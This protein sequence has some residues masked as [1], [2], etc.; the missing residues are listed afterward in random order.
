MA[1]DRRVYPSVFVDSDVT[2]IP[3]IGPERRKPLLHLLAVLDRRPA[4]VDSGHSAGL[5]ISGQ[6][7]NDAGTGWDPRTSVRAYCDPICQ[8][9]SP[10]RVDSRDRSR[11]DSSCPLLFSGGDPASATVAPVNDL[12]D[13]VVLVVDVERPTAETPRAVVEC[14]H[15]ESHP[16]S[17]DARPLR[18][19]PANRPALVGCVLF[20]LRA[21][22]GPVRRPTLLALAAE[23]ASRTV[24]LPVDGVEDVA[25]AVVDPLTTRNRTPVGVLAVPVKRVFEV[26]LRRVGFRVALSPNLELE[27]DSLRGVGYVLTCEWE[28]QDVVDVIAGDTVT[29]VGE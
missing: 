18:I 7:A 10:V 1:S 9:Q 16:T 2:D 14:G 12:R 21:L 11:S 25:H 3:E 28:R 8:P 19:L 17:I 13:G 20:G 4:P 15:R 5:A 23:R 27:P 29:T 6:S 22:P 24:W 26:W